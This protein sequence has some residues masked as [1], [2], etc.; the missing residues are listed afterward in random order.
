MKSEVNILSHK[1]FVNFLY[2]AHYTGTLLDGSKFDSSRDRGTEFKFT[3][4]TGQVIRA[5]DLGFASMKLGEKAI[6]TCKAEYAYGASGSPPKIPA[7]ATLKFDVELLGFAPKPKELWQM[8][9]EEK[10]ESAS[11]SKG[12]GNE[13]VKAGNAFVAAQEYRE[14]LRFLGSA[15]EADA[16][17]PEAKALFLSCNLNLALVSTRIQE[18]GDAINAV[19]D[20]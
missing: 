2:S 20:P 7:N 5:W 16:S 8:T 11:A 17:G 9:P 14:A 3:L 1:I 15:D 19:S 13:A 4:G 18:F 6:L 12:K 10:L